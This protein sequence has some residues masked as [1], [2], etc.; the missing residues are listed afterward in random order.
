MNR[1][2]ALKSEQLQD[3][4]LAAD[5]KAKIGQLPAYIPLLQQ[6]SEDLTLCLLSNEDWI[7]SWGK[8][9]RTFSLMSVVKPF[10]LLYLLSHL[11]SKTVFK[12]VGDRPSQYP[13][14]SLTQL[15]RDRGFPRNPMINSGAITLASLLPGKDALSR[16]ENLRLWLN[17]L[18]KC[19]LFLS[20]AM[21][22]S[23]RSTPNQQNQALARE[24]ETN[25]S[26]KDAVTTVDTYNC[27]CCLSGTIFDLARLGLLLV[28]C[29]PPVQREHCQIVQ[30]LMTTCGLYEAS[31]QFNRKVGLPTK[32]GVSGA[33]LS[34]VPDEGAIACYSPPLDAQGNSVAGLF[35]V[36]QIARLH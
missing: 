26:I 7:F 9:D 31:E 24:L 12:R 34:I 10:L 35:L 28:N 5:R 33:V 8:C 11:G 1:L 17:K 19:E 29:P 14:N 4:I 13:F 18:A 32:S 20:E 3:W 22:N 6:V 30:R 21:L 15:Q 27:I 25:N 23:V 36:E 16:C 2:A